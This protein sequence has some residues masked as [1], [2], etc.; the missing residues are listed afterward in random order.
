MYPT[1]CNFF[2][3]FKTITGTHHYCF[4]YPSMTFAS[5]HVLEWDFWTKKKKKICY[6][7]HT[8]FLHPNNNN[9]KIINLWHYNTAN[10]SLINK[11]IIIINISSSN[12]TPEKSANHASNIQV[13]NL[14]QYKGGYIYVHDFDY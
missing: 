8:M 13:L 4:L 2:L 7:E 12:H 5:F 1:T 10:R 11:P 3:N 14:V 9:K 6:I